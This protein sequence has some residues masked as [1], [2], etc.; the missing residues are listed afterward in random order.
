MLHNK[1]IYIH[2]LVYY[3]TVYGN[4]P[5]K[6]VGIKSDIAIMFGVVLLSETKKKG[7]QLVSSYLIDTNLN[8]MKFTSWCHSHLDITA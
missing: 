2:I 4:L 1:Y 6:R 8:S 7:L 3:V 5:K